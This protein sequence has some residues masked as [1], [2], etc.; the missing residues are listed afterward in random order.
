MLL[1]QFGRLFSGLRSS[2]DSSVQRWLEATHGAQVSRVRIEPCPP[3]GQGVTLARRRA[4]PGD[5]LFKIPRSAI[6]TRAVVTADD[7]QSDF[8]SVM[9]E[10]YDVEQNGSAG[11]IMATAAWL[12]KQR[13]LAE[14]GEWWPYV[15]SLPW[16]D[17]DSV[18]LWNDAELALLRGSSA[19]GE[20]VALR[21]TVAASLPTLFHLFVRLR[22]PVIL[23]D[24]DGEGDVTVILSGDE[25]TA[26]FERALR[27]A[28]ALVTSRAFELGEL[29]AC[30]LVPLLDM[31]NSATCASDAHPFLYEADADAVVL[32]A[33]SVLRRGVEIEDHYGVSSNAGLLV[34]FGYLV[35]DGP[36]ETR[37]VRLE[38]SLDA[39]DPLRAWKRRILRQRGLGGGP[40]GDDQAANGA[41]PGA[42]EAYGA[43]AVVSASFEVFPPG[44]ALPEECKAFLRLAEV[45]RGTDAHARLEASNT[46]WDVLEGRFS[47][48][49]DLADEEAFLGA[50]LERRAAARLHSA[51]TQAVR[52]YA[53]RSDGDASCMA[54]SAVAQP[55]DEEQAVD[56]E[57]E[58]LARALVAQELQALT[59]L[60][61]A[62]GC[63]LEEA[64]PGE[65]TDLGDI[66]SG[67][68]ASTE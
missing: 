30:N 47:I 67:V 8:G 12:L 66:A 29:G 54:S 55:L 20:A 62:Y 9:H 36:L 7:E 57:R 58:R 25:P 65:I 5:E 4:R 52:R 37:G 15:R 18:L 63:A 19:Y 1:L 43:D 14:R 17:M 35:M 60:E 13:G 10:L 3:R 44:G 40:D 38:L 64:G 16:D 45:R 61:Q 56:P 50:E 51:L 33:S 48:F 22:L 59:G 26:A 39:S 68:W 34:F 46:P 23:P 6:V 11:E 27:L 2:P 21:A 42:V 53:R 28:V 41:A 32:R 49:D 31:C 24:P